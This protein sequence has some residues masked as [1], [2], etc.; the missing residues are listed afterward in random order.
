MTSYLLGYDIIF[1]GIWD[2]ITYIGIWNHIY[3]NVASYLLAS[4]K[5]EYAVIFIVICCHI[6]WNI[7]SYLLEYIIIFS[8]IYYHI[9]YNM[10]SYLFIVYSKSNKNNIQTITSVKFLGGILPNNSKNIDI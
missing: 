4:H 3:W 2:H 8:G 9:Y 6:Y 1:I 5:L 7:L 10:S